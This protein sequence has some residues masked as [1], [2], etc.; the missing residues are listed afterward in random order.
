MTLFSGKSARKVQGKKTVPLAGLK[1]DDEVIGVDTV[2]LEPLQQQLILMDQLSATSL[3]LPLLVISTVNGRA[4]YKGNTA[5]L[6]HFTDAICKEVQLSK[7]ESI[8]NKAQFIAIH[9]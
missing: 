2:L 1:F 9:V 7:G 4:T 8:W 6:I 5:M 3:G